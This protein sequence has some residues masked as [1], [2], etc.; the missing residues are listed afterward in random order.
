MARSGTGSRRKGYDFEREICRML[1]NWSG[2]SFRRRGTGFDGADIICPPWWPW[3]I[4]A[5]K[6]ESWSGV[7]DLLRPGSSLS[8]WWKQATVQAGLLG[9]EPMLVWCRNR[10]PVWCAMDWNYFRR[11]GSFLGAIRPSGIVTETFL[12]EGPSHRIR[13]HEFSELL[14]WM[15]PEL[16]RESIGGLRENPEKRS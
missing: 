1:S 9:K 5:K 3:S 4:E 11:Y 13:V 6:D 7:E 16:L 12:E 8:R 15:D 10:S 14:D 2:E